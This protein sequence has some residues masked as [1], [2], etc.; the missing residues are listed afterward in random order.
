MNLKLNLSR[1]S[2]HLSYGQ[3][4]LRAHY[5]EIEKKRN[6]F[7]YAF[8]RIV[9]FSKHSQTRLCPFVHI[10]YGPDGECVI[11]RLN[12]LKMSYIIFTIIT[13]RF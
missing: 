2:K 12:I 1:Y 5:L 10:N 3:H 9:F 7:K 13:K 11:M 6:R 8:M 4:M